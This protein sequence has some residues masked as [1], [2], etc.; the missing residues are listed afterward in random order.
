[1]GLQTK[2]TTPPYLVKS[3]WSLKCSSVWVNWTRFGLVCWMR[4]EG[5]WPSLCF[6]SIRVGMIWANDLMKR[7]AFIMQSQVGIGM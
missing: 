6:V 4:A 5:V 7:S 1:M 3:Y 2:T